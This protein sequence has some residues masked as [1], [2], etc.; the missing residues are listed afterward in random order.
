MNQ[1]NVCTSYLTDT[2]YCYR[3]KNFFFIICLI[4]SFMCVFTSTALCD[5]TK[6]P[7]KYNYVQLATHGCRILKMQ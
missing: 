7:Q 6:N 3:S 2:W 1:F 4:V 5:N